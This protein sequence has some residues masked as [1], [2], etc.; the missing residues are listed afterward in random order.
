MEIDYV[1]LLARIKLTEEERDLFSRQ[2]DGILKYIEK[3]NELDTSGV[4]PTAHV[5]PVKNVFR[6]DNP[7]PSLPRDLILKNS[8]AKDETFYKVPKIIE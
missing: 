1:A 6:E 4:E 8:P 3:L 5:L 2:V 7:V